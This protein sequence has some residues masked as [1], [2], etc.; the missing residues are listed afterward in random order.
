M[1]AITSTR[2]QTNTFSQPRVTSSH[3]FTILGKRLSRR[4]S[5][6]TVNLV[7]N[8][9]NIPMSHTETMFV[10]ISFHMKFKNSFNVTCSVY[11]NQRNQ[12]F[13]FQSGSSISNRCNK[14]LESEMFCILGALKRCL[15]CLLK[16]YL[17]CIAIFLPDIFYFDCHLSFYVKLIGISQ[18]FENHDFLRL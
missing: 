13:C 5:Y 6:K 10:H 18:L 12:G 9:E 3:F 8:R 7:Q 14:S 4:R 16:R 11:D 17:F 2:T 15:M 1:K